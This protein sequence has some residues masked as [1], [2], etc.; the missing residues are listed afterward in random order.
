MYL[1][2]L[3]LQTRELI[4]TFKS[5]GLHEKHA[6]ATWNLGN[7]FSICLKTQENQGKPVSRWPVAGPSG[8]VLTSSQQSGEQKNDKKR[9][10]GKEFPSFSLTC[11]GALLSLLI[12]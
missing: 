3:I 7:H 8:C 12:N 11:A 5:G 9:K 2:L 6:V 1:S 4:L 10:G